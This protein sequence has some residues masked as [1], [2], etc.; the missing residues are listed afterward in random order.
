MLL[1]D[2]VSKRFLKYV[3]LNRDYT[4]FRGIGKR[5]IVL[6]TGENA[7]GLHHAGRIPNQLD[8]QS[9]RDR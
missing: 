9:D 2:F 8:T 3:F 7:R 1:S 5:R 4:E 6:Q